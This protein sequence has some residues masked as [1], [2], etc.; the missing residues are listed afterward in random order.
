MT[1]TH[2]N[3]ISHV[4][5]LNVVH[6]A[7]FRHLGQEHQVLHT[8]RSNLG[9]SSRLFKVKLARIPIQERKTATN[10]F[11]DC[12]G[13]NTE[14]N[15]SENEAK[16]RRWGA[17]AFP[18]PNQQNWLRRALCSMKRLRGSHISRSCRGVSN[19]AVSP[20]WP[21]SLHS[22]CVNRSESFLSLR[23]RDCGAPARRESVR[24]RAAA[25][26]EKNFGSI[27]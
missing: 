25:Q 19:I 3:L 16:T 21:T 27:V 10:H 18:S 7:L 8:Q 2:V 20:T 17:H 12:F 4:A 5:L 22:P 26:E 6:D 24:R 11:E 9:S 1:G 23:F 13:P 15:Q 14:R